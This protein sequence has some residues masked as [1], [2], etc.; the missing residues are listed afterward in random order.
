MKTG[1]GE[2]E[3]VVEVGGQVSLL[4]EDVGCKPIHYRRVYEAH[5]LKKPGKLVTE[6]RSE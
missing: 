5:R 4:L 2:S 1:L 6:S 3:L